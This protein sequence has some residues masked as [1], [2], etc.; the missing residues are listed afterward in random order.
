MPVVPCSQLPGSD[1][2]QGVPFQAR[3]R[4]TAGGG[5]LASTLG[6]AGEVRRG[7]LP[8]LLRWADVV[9]E[10]ANLARNRRPADA[11]MIASRIEVTLSPP[12]LSS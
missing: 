1:R 8:P 4:L 11:Y 3:H 5:Q 2:G 9:P 7:Q 10:T 12:K 6:G